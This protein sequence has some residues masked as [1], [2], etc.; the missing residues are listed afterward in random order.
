MPSTTAAVNPEFETQVRQSFARQGLMST[1]GAWLVSVEA[2]R[3]VI[4]LAYAMRVGQQHGYFHGG[5]IG[6][7]GDNAGGY[8]ALSLM[9]AGS[10]VVTIEYKVNFLKPAKGDLLQAVGQVAR[11]GKSI[12]VTR[13]E[14]ACRSGGILQPCALLQQ[15]LMRVEA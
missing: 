8:A 12:V 4:E 2:G 1:L 9:P 11:A 6:A 3:V 10:E 13:V 15:T 14:I 5:V 7:I